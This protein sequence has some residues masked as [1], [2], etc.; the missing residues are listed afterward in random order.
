MLL[1]RQPHIIVASIGHITVVSLTPGMLLVLDKILVVCVVL[2]P[3]L[4]FTWAWL[5]RAVLRW[6]LNA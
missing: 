4:L 5:T 2:C 3:S 6:W 1:Y